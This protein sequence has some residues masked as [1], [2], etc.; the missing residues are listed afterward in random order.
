VVNRSVVVLPLELFGIVAIESEVSVPVKMKGE[1]TFKVSVYGGPYEPMPSV[2]LLALEELRVH[3]TSAELFVSTF[4]LVKRRS[5]FCPGA[6]V[7]C[8]N[9]R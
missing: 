3:D 2:A 4:V 6:L 9:P 8:Q 7:A 5:R 1:D